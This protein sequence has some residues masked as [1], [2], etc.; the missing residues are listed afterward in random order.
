MFGVNLWCMHVP[1]QNASQPYV[2]YM[3]H[4]WSID[5]PQAFFVNFWNTCV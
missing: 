2:V 3:H 4:S 5:M 1:M